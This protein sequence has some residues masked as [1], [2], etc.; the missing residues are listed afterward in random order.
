MNLILVIGS[1][2]FIG[3][4]LLKGNNYIGLTRQEV[5]CTI[6]TQ[7][8][9]YF[10]KN[11]YDIVIHCSAVG[12][13]N[14]DNSDNSDI[15]VKNILMFENVVKHL[16]K[17]FSKLI[18]FSSGAALRGNPPTDP[19]GLSKWII[20]KRIKTIQNAYSLRIWGCYGEGELSTRFSA[21]CKRDKHIV[22]NKDKYFDFVSIK[23]VIDIVNLYIDDKID[24][25]FYNF[26]STEP[27][28]LLSEWAVFFGATYTILD[29]S[30]L[31]ESYTYY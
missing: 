11:K 24:D 16:G 15:C 22:I 5:D 9:E 17:S 6:P 7:V 29:T 25:K 31:D 4:N 3:N 27:P 26:G 30:S 18:Y 2:G 1:N 12:V 13:T 14:N 23:E 28:K 19:Y 21:I 20:D 10:S 8:D